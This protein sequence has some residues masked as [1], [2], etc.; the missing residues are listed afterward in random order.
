LHT[1]RQRFFALVQQAV[2]GYAGTMQYVV[3]DR[4]LVVF[5]A[6]VAQED[7]ARRAVLAA[8]RLRDGLRHHDTELAPWTGRE[9]AACMGLHTGEVIVGP[10]GVEPYQVALAVGD[11]TQMA[12]QLLRLAEPGD[13]VLSAATG[14]LV[15]VWLRLELRASGSIPGMTA[16]QTVYKVLGL[17]ANH[18]VWGWQGRRIVR[19][20]VGRQRDMGTLHDLLAQAEDGRGQIVGIAGEP[21]IGKS[22]FL[23]EFRQQVRHRS[24]TYLAGRC[25]SYGQATPYLPLLDLVRQACG[26]SEHDTPAEMAA[27]VGQYLQDVSMEVEAWA[28]YVLRFLGREDSTAHLPPLSPQAIRTR[29]FEALIQMQLHASR[30]RPLL[31]EVEDLHWIDPAS[32]EWL[33]ALIERLTGVPIMLLLSYRAGYQPAWMGKSYATQLALQRLTTDESRQMV[34]VMLSPQAASDALVQDIVAKG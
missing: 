17:A 28:P 32:E 2:Q 3:D 21:G 7:H 14:R 20:F 1:L 29:I 16:P 22:R 9:Q 33:L 6:P 10:I 24:V 23:Y 12:E 34:R 5:G 26:L 27:R 30:Q 15:H 25:V 4:C 13:I 19:Q 11:T 8:L 18:P 31:L